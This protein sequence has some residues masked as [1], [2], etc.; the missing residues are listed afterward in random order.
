M[1]EAT[2]SK[3]RSWLPTLTGSVDKWGALAVL[4]LIAVVFS[5]LRPAT[6]PT[7]QN[8]TTILSTQAI[9]AILAI[10]LLVPLASGEFD[11]S[12]GF[13]LGFCAMLTAV[14][15]GQFGLPTAATIPIVLLVGVAVGLL[16]GIAVVRIKI[17][18]FIATLGVGTILSG[19]TIWVSNG[20]VVFQGIPKDLLAL[21]R[22]QLIGL[23]LTVFYMIFVILVFWFVLEQTPYGRYIHAIGAGRETVRLAGLP[24]DRLRI[25][26]FVVSGFMASVAGVLQTAMVGSANPNAGPDFLLPAFAAA[27]LGATTIRPGRFNV[28]GTIVALFLLAIGIAGLQQLGAPF[29]VAPVFNGAALLVAVGLAAGRRSQ[30]ARD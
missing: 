25:S 29:W 24:T 17:N 20:N 12:I 5:V 26:A 6:F 18:A 9:L 19:L 15:S 16:N 23:P 14:L 27:F 21:G 22:T 8:L 28:L 13:N 10:G 11:L 3:T 4:I 1:T 7:F 30:A 2:T